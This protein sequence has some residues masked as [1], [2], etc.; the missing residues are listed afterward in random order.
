MTNREKLFQFILSALTA[1]AA[2]FGARYGIPIPPPQVT[3]PPP[4][5]VTPPIDTQP[6]PVEK[7]DPLAA[8]GR[9]QFGTSGCSAT[10]IGTRRTDGR[11]LVLSAAHCVKE[12]GQRGSMRLRDGRSVGLVVLAI[13]RTADCSWLTTD[14]TSETF[15]HAELI[16]ATPAPGSKLWH[17]GFGVDNPGNREDGELVDGPDAKGQVHMRLSVSSGDSG[18]GIISTDTGR[19]ISC[20]CCTA[21]MARKADV[22]GASPEAI[23]KLRPT[24][25]A[26]DDWQPLPIPIRDAM[27]GP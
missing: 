22:W 27:R 26:A 10:V 18:G 14:P 5:V 15:P 7:A 3:V 21:G 2:V 1:V 24:S 23:A 9:I 17:A 25:M 11:Y 20:V 16:E 8:I 6:G 4:V 12:K 13:D 19:V